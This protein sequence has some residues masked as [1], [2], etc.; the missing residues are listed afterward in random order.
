M[1]GRTLTKVADGRLADLPLT[2]RFWDGSEL[3]LG[4]EPRAA[5]V[6]V[7]GRAAVS[8]LVR[9]PSP[10]GL[11][12]A[13]VIGELDVEGELDRV[14]ELRRR[15]KGARLT[16]ADRIR[17]AIAALGVAGP[18]ALR[19]PAVPAS[20]ARQHGRPHSLARDRSAIHHHYDVSNRFYELLLGPSLSYSCARFESSEDSLE[21]AQ[22]QKHDLICRRLELQPGERLLDI[23]CG[24]GSLLLHAVRNYGARGVGVTLSERQAELARE[25]VRDAGLSDQIEIRIADY[26]EL[27]DGPYDKVASIGMYEHVG[28]GNYGT[29]AGTIQALLR[30]HGLFLNDG[31]ARL[32]SPPRRGPTFIGRYVFPDGEL[33]PITELL[34]A[35][36]RAELE[37]RAAESLR[38]DY[39]LTL[40]RWYSNVERHRDQARGEIGEQRVRVWEAYLLGSAQAFEDGEITNFHVVAQRRR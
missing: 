32:F 8:R 30:P 25:R 38:E 5:T 7:R 27:R 37:I 3:R 18:A 23:G 13:W 6:L 22:A 26:R 4:A 31:I 20:A 15:L 16:A 9:H 14:L 34:R 39:A 1:L 36:E 33:L 17:M 12:S 24:W 10:L 21:T 35:L 29:Y 28:A 2:F 40:R 19:P 11:A